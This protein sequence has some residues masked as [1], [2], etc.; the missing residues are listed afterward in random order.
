MKYDY[1]IIGQGLAGSILAYQL[2]KRGKSIAIIDERKS[3]TS[4]KIGAGLVNPF[5]GPRMAK[6]WKI[7]SLFP[8]LKSFYKE[9]EGETH[10]TFFNEK[11]IYRPFASIEQL[12][13]WDG[14]STSH[15]HQNFIKQHPGKNVH[16]KNI[17]DPFGGVEI[18]GAVLNMPV[19]IS[20]IFQYLSTK[21]TYIT[22][23]FDENALEINNDE[24]NYKGIQASNII[25]CNGYQI[26]QSKYFGWLPIAPVKGEVLHLKL[27]LDFETIY[28]KSGFIIPQDNG[29]YK[30]GSTYDRNDLTEKP[31]DLGKN[32]I[33]KNLD[34]LLKMNYEIMQHQAGIR[35]GTKTRRP[36]IGR[37]PKHQRISI[38]NGMGT[39]GVSLAP[40][41]CDQFVKY[42]L[43]DNYLDEEVD[44]KKYYSLYFK[45]HFSKEN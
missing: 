8:F 44:I 30:A 42:L 7:E 18:Y 37:H 31:T 13:D 23:R 45:S 9:V 27:N 16:S 14:R 39:K 43:D 32:V 36:L 11:I 4:S 28:S 29:Y 3:I 22:E 35:P 15:D 19:F 25:F 1:L 17:E 24:I 12:N 26:Q 6:S 21:C 2:L 10:T 41:F 38:F 5:T 40:F 33:T 20:S 34:S